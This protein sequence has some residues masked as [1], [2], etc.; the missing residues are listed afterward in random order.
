[1]VYTISV[2]GI[3]LHAKVGLYPEE[4]IKGNQFEI[5]VAVQV[6]ADENGECPFIDYTLINELV[7]QIFSKPNDLLETVAKEIFESL[8]STFSTI[9]YTKVTI[10]KLH[11]PMNG[12]VQYSQVICEG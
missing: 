2:N 5:D 7:H 6:T 4:K 9:H 1:M 11:P 8:R 12:T 3:A 10:R